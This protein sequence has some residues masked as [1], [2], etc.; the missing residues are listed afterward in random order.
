M[1]SYYRQI[2]TAL[3]TVIKTPEVQKKKLSVWV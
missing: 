1:F 3:Y 2:F